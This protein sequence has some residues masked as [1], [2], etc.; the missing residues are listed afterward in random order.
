MGNGQWSMIK[1]I[2]VLFTIHPIY[3]FLKIKIMEN[4]RG[5]NRNLDQQKSRLSESESYS[6]E[7]NVSSSRGGSQRQENLSEENESLQSDQQTVSTTRG[8]G[9][10]N[11]IDR[12]RTSRGTEQGRSGSGISTKRNVSGSDFDGQVSPE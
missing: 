2:K 5:Q 1:F 10:T 3:S 4:S 12:N 6:S 8:A 11:D 7:Q 9:G